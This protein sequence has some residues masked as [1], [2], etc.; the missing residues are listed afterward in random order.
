M[1]T[2]RGRLGRWGEEHARRYLEGKG[3]T[4]SETNYRSRWGEVDIVSRLGEELV[5]VEVKT[6]RGIA[7]GTPE[8]S[9]TAAKSQRLIATAQD[10]LQ[11]NGLEQSR[12]RIDLI[13]IHLDETGKL[14]EVNHLENAVG[15]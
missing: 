9:I 10:Y 11:K 13:S 14:L 6:R 4:V 15:E 8:E 12:W 3:Y 5:F 7:F 2:P 1:A